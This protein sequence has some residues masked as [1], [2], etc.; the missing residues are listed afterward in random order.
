MAAVAVGNVS[1]WLWLVGALSYIALLAVAPVVAFWL[2][3]ALA[4]VAAL[5]WRQNPKVARRCLYALALVL[6]IYGFLW[7]GVHSVSHPG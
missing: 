7:W 6:V 1:R 3:A 4:P 2:P 5:M